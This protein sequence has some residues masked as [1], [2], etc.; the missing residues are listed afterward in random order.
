MK[1]AILGP[2]DINRLSALMEK[3]ITES[4]CYLF[5]VVCG[6]TD[7]TRIKTSVAYRWATANGAPVE[8][9]IEKDIDKLIEQLVN[10]ID[11]VVAA[12]DENPHIKRIIMK[13]N[14]LGKHGSVENYETNRNNYR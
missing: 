4:Q 5:T 2:W 13:M 3:L 6:G 1:I 7:E 12:N 8:F 9:L 11:Y 14:M 10:K